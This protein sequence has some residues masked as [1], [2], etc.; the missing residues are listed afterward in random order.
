MKSPKAVEYCKGRD[1][2]GLCEL[3]FARLLR[4][5]AQTTEMSLPKCMRQRS[6]CGGITAYQESLLL[7]LPYS[8]SPKN[9]KSTTCNKCSRLGGDLESK[10]AVRKLA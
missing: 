7:L 2:G 5:Q 6:F 3:V 4:H 10:A 9:M 1:K 8:N